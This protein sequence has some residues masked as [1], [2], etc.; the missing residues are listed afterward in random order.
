M[1][2]RQAYEMMKTK[3]IT[4]CYPHINRIILY[5]HRCDGVH[6]TAKQAYGLSQYMDDIS[7]VVKAELYVDDWYVVRVYLIL[8]EDCTIYSYVPYLAGQIKEEGEP[9]YDFLENVDWELF[10]EYWVK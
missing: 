6:L 10:D 8:N 5:F 3:P 7:R 4:R 9:L 1:S 2:A